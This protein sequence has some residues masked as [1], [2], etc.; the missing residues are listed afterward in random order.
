MWKDV[1]SSRVYVMINSEN[2]CNCILS[3]LLGWQAWNVP[4]V[5]LTFIWFFL[6]SL[7][8][9]RPPRPVFV[10]TLPE[11]P[12]AVALTAALSSSLT[13]SLSAFALRNVSSVGFCVFSP[14]TLTARLPSGATAKIKHRIRV[15][16]QETSSHQEKVNSE[17]SPVS[18]RPDRAES[19]ASSEQLR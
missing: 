4:H 12:R 19:R 2:V 3:T 9:L 7:V 13:H 16:A 14:L 11:A 15:V 8:Y 17:V 18:Q 10:L 5:S 6:R 1:L